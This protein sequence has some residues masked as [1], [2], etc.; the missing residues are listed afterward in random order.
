M[1]VP[2]SC[3]ERVWLGKQIEYNYNLC[4]VYLMDRNACDKYVHSKSYSV[5]PS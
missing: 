4:L 1:I 2:Y 5:V 3:V